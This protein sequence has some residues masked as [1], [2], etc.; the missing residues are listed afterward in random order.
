MDSIVVIVYFV[1]G[2]VITSLVLETGLATP[3]RKYYRLKGT[4]LQS[5]SREVF[6]RP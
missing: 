5:Q 6:L 3:A 4:S 1:L 2:Y